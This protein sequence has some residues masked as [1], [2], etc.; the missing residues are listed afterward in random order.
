VLHAS[1]TTPSVDVWVNDGGPAVEALSFGAGT[2]YLP[3][4]PGPANFKVAAAGQGSPTPAALDF[5]LVL[6]P[7][8]S[9]TAVAWGNAT[10]A[11]LALVDDAAGLASGDIRLQVVHAAEGVGQVDVIAVDLG[12]TLISDF[13]EGEVAT[14]DLPQGAYAVGLDLDNDAVA[15]VIFDVPD[16]GANAVVDV[17]AV[18]DGATPKLLAQLPD[19]S[20]ALL[21]PRG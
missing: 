16:L 13:D 18:L 7:G 20:T 3:L 9:Y 21:D 1:P 15:D 6:D 19:G 17:L 2:G 11:P 8:V 5:D 14:L 4:T 12:A 10:V